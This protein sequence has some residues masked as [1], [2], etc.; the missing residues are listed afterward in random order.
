M[1]AFTFHISGQPKGQGS[2]TLWRAP[3]GSNRTKYPAQTVE[4]RNH[5][6]HE[7]RQSWG[8]LPVMRGPV[9]VEVLFAMARP[10]VHYG[11]GRNAGKV[12]D[13]A[14]EWP[15]TYPD[16]DKAAR[17]V[18]DAL[19]I[20]GV[21]EDDVNVVSLRCTKVYDEAPHTLIKVMEL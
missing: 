17:L 4:H 9:R 3:D 16:I 2:M 18:C 6:I 14:P 8:D 1:T 21:I 19:T 20:A 5:V 13:S 11:T 12:K 15:T 7:L 10:K